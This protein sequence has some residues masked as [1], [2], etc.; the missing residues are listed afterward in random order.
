[1]QQELWAVDLSLHYSD[2]LAMYRLLQF[3]TGGH[4]NPETHYFDVIP[5]KKEEK[6][7]RRKKIK[8]VPEVSFV[9]AYTNP[10][11]KGCSLEYL[12]FRDIY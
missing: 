1:M 11:V 8:E 10:P 4:L 6:K 9:F 3:S 12:H 5:V 2:T 7:S